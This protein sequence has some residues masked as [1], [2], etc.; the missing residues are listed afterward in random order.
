MVPS[1]SQKIV[2]VDWL[3]LSMDICRCSLDV[4]WML[5]NHHFEHLMGFGGVGNILVA[6]AA[7]LGNSIQKLHLSG[8]WWIIELSLSSSVVKKSD[9]LSLT[10][11]NTYINMYIH[12]M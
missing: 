1:S 4:R 7:S 12:V 2:V 3:H 10:E 6:R 11:Y 9:L 5:E 8:K